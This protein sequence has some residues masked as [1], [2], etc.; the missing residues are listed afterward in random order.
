MSLSKS[1]GLLGFDQV[2]ES[3]NNII[4]RSDFIF[5]NVHGTFTHIH[6]DSL[7]DARVETI[8]AYKTLGKMVSRAKLLND[9][10]LS[11]RALDYDF[12]YWEMQEIVIIIS[13]LYNYIE[14]YNLCKRMN[15]NIKL[16]YE[17]IPF[18]N[19]SIEELQLLLL[20]AI[21]SFTKESMKRI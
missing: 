6:Y 7:D 1:L 14:I 9:V 11:N 17:D 15:T 12:E 21:E 16:K 19:P 20:E 8:K 18:K 5:N 3:Y 2:I 10:E 4:K 13:N